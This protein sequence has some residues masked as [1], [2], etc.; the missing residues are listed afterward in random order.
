MINVLDFEGDGLI[1]RFINVS[2]ETLMKHR[3]FSRE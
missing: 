3:W 2:C 1:L